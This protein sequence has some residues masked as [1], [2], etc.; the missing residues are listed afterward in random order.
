ML[1]ISTPFSMYLICL[2][3]LFVPF[4]RAIRSFYIVKIFTP[5]GLLTTYY[6]LKQSLLNRPAVNVLHRN[7]ILHAGHGGKEI[8][9][10]RFGLRV[11]IGVGI[12]EER[13]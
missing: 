10:F 1:L 2:C 8:Y 3:A 11:G 7:T 9:E 6:S 5:Q 4:L 13:R 12:V